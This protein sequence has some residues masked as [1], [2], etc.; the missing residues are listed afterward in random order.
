MGNRNFDIGDKMTPEQALDVL[1]QISVIAKMDFNSH[2]QGQAALKVIDDLIK[3]T[4]G[5]QNV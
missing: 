5:E 2:L 3:K 1:R 4:K